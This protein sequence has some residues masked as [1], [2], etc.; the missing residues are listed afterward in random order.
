VALGLCNQ[1]GDSRAGDAG[2][3]ARHDQPRPTRG[4]LSAG[5]RL[6]Q[7]ATHHRAPVATPPDRPAQPR[8]HPRQCRGRARL[9]RARLPRQPRSADGL[10]RRTGQGR[11]GQGLGLPQ[12]RLHGRR[13]IAGGGDGKKLAG[14]G[15]PAPQY[16]LRGTR[17]VVPVFQI[18]R[19]EQHHREPASQRSVARHG[20]RKARTRV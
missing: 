6:A 18:D 1:T 13:R 4:A 16:T 17:P 3:C 19:H 10:L 14:S 12:L 20:R 15:E 8:R 7:C 5:F 2:S 11:A 9:L